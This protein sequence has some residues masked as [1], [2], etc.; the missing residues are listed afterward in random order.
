MIEE[1]SFREIL[2]DLSER[3]SDMEPGKEYEVLLPCGT[4][5][6]I[7]P[8]YKWDYEEIEGFHITAS[9]PLNFAVSYGKTDYGCVETTE[10]VSP[11]QSAWNNHLELFVSVSA[12][13]TLRAVSALLHKAATKTEV[14]V[15]ES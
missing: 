15:V 4:K 6:T 13:Q 8:Q 3:L 9:D 7:E 5:L 2:T 11:G 14:E 12:L 1:K 10:P